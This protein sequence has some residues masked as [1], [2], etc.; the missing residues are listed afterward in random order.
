VPIVSAHFP[1][2]YTPSEEAAR[3]QIYGD[4]SGLLQQHAVIT[5]RRHASAEYAVVACPSVSVTSRSSIKT[6]ES[7]EL[8][9]PSTYPTQCCKEI[10][11]SPKIRALP[12]GTHIHTRLTALCPGLPGLAGTRKVK[13]TWILLKHETVSGSGISWAIQYASLHLAPD[14]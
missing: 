1:S 7:I 3:V 4:A 2:L 8:G 11:E 6:A 10:R 14:R 5:A 12:C 9:F 13:P